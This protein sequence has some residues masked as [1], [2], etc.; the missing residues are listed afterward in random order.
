MICHV[1]AMAMKLNEKWKVI[2]YQNWNFEGC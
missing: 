1:V 2:A